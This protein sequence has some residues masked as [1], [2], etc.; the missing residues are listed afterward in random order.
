MGVMIVL[1]LFYG[2]KKDSANGRLFIW[3]NTIMAWSEAPLFGVGIDGF[4]RAYAEAQHDYFKKGNALEQD[5][6][7]T[8]LAGVVEAAFNEPLA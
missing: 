3:Q 6:R 7:Y 4:E 5:S 1:A 2:L 8:E